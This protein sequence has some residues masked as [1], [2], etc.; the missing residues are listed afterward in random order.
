MPLTFLWLLRSIP[1]RG[2]VKEHGIPRH[3]SGD[4]AVENALKWDQRQRENVWPVRVD[5]KH[6]IF[7]SRNRMGWWEFSALLP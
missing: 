7:F 5:L 1:G 4:V 2:S 3:S 6:R